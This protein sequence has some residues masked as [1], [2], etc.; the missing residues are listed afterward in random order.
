M[1]VVPPDD[2]RWNSIGQGVRRVGLWRRG[3][4]AEQ[5]HPRYRD[6]AMRDHLS[7]GHPDDTLLLYVGR[8]APEKQLEQ[9]RSV[10]ECVPGTRLALIGGGPY[11]ATLERYFEGL[12]VA[13]PG[14][15][16]G[17]RLSRAYASA[18]IF[19][20]PSAFESFGLVLLEAMASGIPVVSARVGGAQD[21]ITEGESGYTYAVSDVEA[22]VQAVK[23][24][25]TE[26]GKLQG[27][28]Q[29]ARAQAEQQSWPH[30]M[31]EL[32][33]CYEAILAGQPPPI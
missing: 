25:V 14:Y 8:L 1:T 6:A 13:F 3:V 26:P 12:P 10:L 27:M 19:V 18:D 30:M 9:L 21:M 24:I 4:D 15:M 20:F 31:D 5:Y 23:R 11:R 33:A 22:L 32:I 7:E 16:T 17:E 28:G 29:S 2:E